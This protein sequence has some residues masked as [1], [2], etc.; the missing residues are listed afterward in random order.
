MGAVYS[1]RDVLTFALDI[2]L[3]RIHYDTLRGYRA[4]NICGG[5]EFTPLPK[6]MPV[7][8]ALRVGAF[9]NMVESDYSPLMTLGLGGKFWKFS[10]DA[11]GRVSW[12]DKISIESGEN[13]ADVFERASF[14]VTAAFATEF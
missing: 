6:E 1:F 11:G 7:S 13:K 4:Q 2:D 10:V 8:V 12:F 3:N 5:V 9:K 14:G